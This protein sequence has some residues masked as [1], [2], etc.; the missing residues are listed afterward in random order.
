L[1]A[2]AALLAELGDLAWYPSLGVG[3]AGGGAAD[4]ARVIPAVTAARAALVAEGGSLVVEAAPAELRAAIDAWG[5]RPQ[6]FAI[7]ERLKRRFDPEGRLNPGRF[8]GGL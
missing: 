5:P 6:S 8:V 3:V 4:P 7:M 1:P 2:I